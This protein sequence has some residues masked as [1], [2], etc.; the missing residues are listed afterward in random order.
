MI[1]LA[2]ARHVAMFI[3][4]MDRFWRGP[5]WWLPIAFV[6]LLGAYG[7]IAGAFSSVA[8]SIAMLVGGA[9]VL[10]ASVIAH[11][12]AVKRHRDSAT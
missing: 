3:I 4:V 7:L 8:F 11:E 1:D 6:A 2:Y 9:V 5:V 10:A 12:A